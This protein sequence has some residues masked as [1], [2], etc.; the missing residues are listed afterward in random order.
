MVFASLSL[1]NR[2][3][4]DL[5]GIIRSSG[6]ALAMLV[7]LT[8]MSYAAA[9]S[10]AVPDMWSNVTLRVIMRATLG[11]NLIHFWVDTFIWKFSEKEIRD[12]HG[13]AFNF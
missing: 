12:L 5:R 10:V 6:F 11:I 7:G 2:E 8:L 13:Q 1:R 4:V 9:Q 3:N